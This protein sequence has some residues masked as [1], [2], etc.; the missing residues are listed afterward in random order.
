M[1]LEMLY[2]TVLQLQGHISQY[3]KTLHTASLCELSF[4]SFID[5]IVKLHEFLYHFDTNTTK[6]VCTIQDNVHMFTYC[7]QNYS[8]PSTVQKS[9]RQKFVLNV[10]NQML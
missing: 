4:L 9:I 6:T 2:I 7:F 10:K 8:K 5:H 1:S 3:F